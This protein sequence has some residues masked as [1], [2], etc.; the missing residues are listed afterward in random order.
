MTPAPVNQSCRLDHYPAAHTSGSRDTS[1]IRLIVLHD[2]EGGT[3]A[4][5]AAWF[6]NPASTGS[7]HIVVDETECQR[8]LPNTAIP[9]AAPNANTD[10]FHIEMCGRA[11]YTNIVWKQQH[12]MTVDRAAYK[13]ALHCYRLGIPA[14][15][16]GPRGLAANRSGITTHRNVSTW[17]ARAGLPGDHSHT[18]PGL[19]FPRWWFMRRVRH[20]LAAIKAGKGG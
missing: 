3:A 14:R 11:S 9:W 5:V 15:W 1:A 19:F 7:A 13:A 20:H 6:Q 10:G 4:G 16:V 18:D 12:R 8:C 2:T 17:S